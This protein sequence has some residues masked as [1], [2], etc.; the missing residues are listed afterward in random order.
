MGFLFLPLLLYDEIA[1]GCIKVVI[2]RQSS[3]SMISFLKAGQVPN[4]NAQSV[5]DVLAS[6]A[7]A[8]TSY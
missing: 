5:L 8:L 2:V 3:R 6:I 7:D 4:S 1:Y